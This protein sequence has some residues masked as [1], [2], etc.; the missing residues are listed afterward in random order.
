MVLGV[1]NKMTNAINI[2][3]G[4]V[5]TIRA[6]SRVRSYNPSKRKFILMRNQKVKVDTQFNFIPSLHGRGP[7][8]SWAGSGRYWN[9]TDIKNV[10]A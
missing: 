5:V 2:N 10:I 4:D 3:R 9:F 8:I 7:E 6:G 1:E